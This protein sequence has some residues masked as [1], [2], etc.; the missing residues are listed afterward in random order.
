MSRHLQ[1]TFRFNQTPS[2]SMLVE[3]RACESGRLDWSSSKIGLFCRTPPPFR[4]SSFPQPTTQPDTDWQE[5]FSVYSLHPEQ[6]RQF[7]HQEEHKAT[8]DNSITE[9]AHKVQ[10]VIESRKPQGSRQTSNLQASSNDIQ[11][12][13]AAASSSGETPHPS[14]D[15]QHETPSCG[16]QTTPHTTTNASLNTQG[17]DEGTTNTH[18]FSRSESRDREDEEMDDDLEDEEMLDASEDGRPEPQTAAEKAARIAEKKKMKR[19]RLTHQQTRFLMSEFAKQP[20]PDASHRERLSREIPGQSPRQ[21]QVWFQNRRAKIKRMNADDRERMMRMRAVP[22]DFDNVQALHSPYGATNHG[23][24]T[25][26]QSPVDYTQPN[27][28]DPT[29]MRPMMTVDTMRRQHSNEHLSNTGLSP[30]FGM[31][32]FSQ[33]P[34]G[35]MS[36]PDVLSP[37]SMNAGDRFYSHPSPTSSG[38]RTANP[39]A[40]R[41]NSID[42]SYQMQQRHP[43]Q[44]I[45]PLQI[46]DSM[47]RARSESLQTPL[48]SSMSWT[49]D[50]LD[51]ANYQPA[52]AASSPGMPNTQQQRSSYHPEQPRSHPPTG[53]PFDANSHSSTGLQTPSITY[54]PAQTSSNSDAMSRLRANSTSAFPASL[55][56]RT[57]VQYRAMPAQQ[58]PPQ[59]PQNIARAAPFSS[60]FSGFQSAPLTAPVDFNLPRTP[61]NFET[62][63]MSA[64]MAAPADFS[65]AYN[66]ASSPPGQIQRSASQDENTFQQ[67]QGNQAAGEQRQA[68][69]SGFLRSEEYISERRRSY[70]MPGFQNP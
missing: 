40:T 23:L 33:G 54:P 18:E 6:E 19:F 30:A 5:Q 13:P 28:G 60:P 65:E 2:F 47:S 46:R 36:S 51:Y 41:Q 56:L 22:D 12:P 1:R 25:P 53:N 9:D 70:T 7:Q 42:N 10:Q 38:P 64:P 63:Q 8:L 15:L 66:R 34:I 14:S 20:H 49:G 29:M 48:R 45:M 4:M 21:V 16:A 57:S 24:S 43:P 50:S 35:S 39:F 27:Y 37:L 11:H 62:L 69:S 26:M 59:R 31:V 32:G 67:Q 44:R 17:K 52:G 61:A 58:S 55:D 3:T 68:T